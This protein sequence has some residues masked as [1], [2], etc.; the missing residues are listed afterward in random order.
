MWNPGDQVLQQ[1]VWFGSLLSARPRTA[2]DRHVLTQT[3]PHAPHSVWLFWNGD[4][5]LN[6]WYVN[7]QEPLERNPRGIIE[8]D[9]TLDLYL[10]DIIWLAPLPWRVKDICG[11]TRQRLRTFRMLGEPEHPSRLQECDD[12]LCH[13]ENDQCHHCL[14]QEQTGAHDQIPLR[15]LEQEEPK[16]SLK[17]TSPAQNVPRL[18]CT[19]LGRDKLEVGLIADQENGQETQD[20]RSCAGLVI[21]GLKGQSANEGGEL[22]EV[23]PL[24]QKGTVVG[25]QASIASELAVHTIDDVSD[26]KYDSCPNQ[27]C[28]VISKDEYTGQDSDTEGENREP[29]RR[30]P[31]PIR[32]QRQNQ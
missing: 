5:T 22:D 18:D 3:P 6:C 1:S 27:A 15:F 7:L 21:G 14:I 29:V 32:D 13:D 10:E 11:Y 25:R 16:V 30:D 20:Q 2:G 12:S 4:W 24:V 19:L 8:R 17:K 9:Q 31:A 23:G 28:T 26:L